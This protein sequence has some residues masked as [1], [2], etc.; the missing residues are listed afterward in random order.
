[1][2]LLSPGDDDI[3]CQVINGDVYDGVKYWVHSYRRANALNKSIW[4][5]YVSNTDPFPIEPR[6]GHETQG[7]KFGLRHVHLGPSLGLVIPVLP[8]LSF[9]YVPILPRAQSHRHLT[10]RALSQVLN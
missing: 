10:Y 5:F 9:L 6:T 1:M 3:L 4:Y 8:A 2:I 7:K